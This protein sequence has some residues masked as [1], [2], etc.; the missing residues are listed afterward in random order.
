MLPPPPPSKAN[1]VQ[2][3]NWGIFVHL[4]KL[5][6]LPQ[7]SLQ[8][9]EKTHESYHILFLSSSNQTLLKKFSFLIFSPSFF[10]LNYI[11]YIYIFIILS[12]IRSIKHTLEVQSNLLSNFII[13]HKSGIKYFLRWSIK[14]MP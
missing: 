14:K 1:V 12:K 13:F 10:F 6:S 7:F 9:K 3:S 8:F 11:Y 2:E 4:T 5:H